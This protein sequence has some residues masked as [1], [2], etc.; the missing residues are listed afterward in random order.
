[1]LTPKILWKFSR[2]APAKATIV[3]VVAAYALAMQHTGVVRFEAA[4]FALTMLCAAGLYVSGS[5]ISQMSDVEIDRINKPELPLASG[6]MTMK[7]AIGA[8]AGAAVLALVIAASQSW[9][10]L[11]TVLLLL[12][13]GL[14]YSLPPVRLKGSAFGAGGLIAISRGLILPLGV[15][16]HFNQVL[17]GA[18]D[19]SFEALALAVVSFGIMSGV[20]LIKDIPDIEG[21]SR[22][23]LRTAAIVFGPGRTFNLAVGLVCLAYGALIALGLG[24]MPLLG[25]AVLLVSHLGLLAF[26]L[27]KSRRVK[28]DDKTSAGHF[29]HL[30]WKLLYVEQ[31]VF[32]AICFLA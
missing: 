12:L 23:G 16:A 30:L 11:L 26:F 2:P 7:E 8:T 32:P 10:L 9:S 15:F 28:P 1:M 4:A 13:N 22:N 20:A 19:L 6:A 18:P 17:T 24:R 27:L 14:L 29:Y 5:G 31:V 3:Q 21:D 25:W